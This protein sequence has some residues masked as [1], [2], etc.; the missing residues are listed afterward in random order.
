MCSTR[1]TP[2]ATPTP[3]APS[4]TCLCLALAAHA[5]HH[6]SCSLRRYRD[7]LISNSKVVANASD[8]TVF[9]AV[10]LEHAMS[11]A[12]GEIVDASHVDIL[13]L[14]K[15][16]S[17]VV[18]WIRDSVDVNMYGTAGGYTAL[19]TASEY[20]ADFAQYSPSTYRVERTSPLKLAITAYH[21]S[22]RELDEGGVHAKVKCSY[23]LDDSQLT[24]GHFPGEDWATLKKSLWAPWC[25]YWV[26][27]ANVLVEA[28]GAMKTIVATPDAGV[29]YMRGHAIPK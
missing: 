27:G 10:N 26:T 7:L 13:G 6:L 29:L 8:R 19:A 20:P 3:D 4:T 1:T 23:P 22:S 2:G 16:G 17:T 14:K 15:E 5:L 25:G 28:D 9:Y 18:L 21:R 24:T 11:E 12:N